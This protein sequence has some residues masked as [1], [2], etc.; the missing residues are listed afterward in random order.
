VASRLGLDPADAESALRDRSYRPRVEVD[1]ASGTAAGATG[2]PTFFID[3][4]R[5][6]GH[7]RQLG[8]IIPAALEAQ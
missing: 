2:T 5:L 6:S 1:I 8:Q 4:E 7:W 3:G